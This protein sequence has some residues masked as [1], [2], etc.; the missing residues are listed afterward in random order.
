MKDL[1][2]GFVAIGLACLI[3]VFTA[4]ATMRYVDLNS[5]NSTS[6]FIDSDFVFS[7]ENDL[8]HLGCLSGQFVDQ[9]RTG[10]RVAESG[11]G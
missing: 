8:A 3:F 6:P 4:S 10:F 7:A 9:S 2:Y 5:T 11:L 1:Q